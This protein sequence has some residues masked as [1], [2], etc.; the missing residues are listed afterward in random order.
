MSYFQSFNHSQC[1][2]PFIHYH[3]FIHLPTRSFRSN[4]SHYFFLFIH[5]IKISFLRLITYFYLQHPFIQ[6][7]KSVSVLNSM[8]Q[9]AL[10][11]MEEESTR[12]DNEVISSLNLHCIAGNNFSLFT[13]QVPFL[14]LLL[15]GHFTNW[16]GH[17]LWTDNTLKRIQA[18]HF[19]LQ[20]SLIIQKLNDLSNGR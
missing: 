2:F 7:A 9:E 11:I 1:F 14:I 4:L 15:V 19:L 3:S 16:T 5:S 12:E 20:N 17:N 13:W 10:S 6:S 18:I 8:I